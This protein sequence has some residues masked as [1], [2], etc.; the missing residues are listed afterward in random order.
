M[1][2]GR[3]VR[4]VHPRVA[5]SLRTDAGTDAFN[6][7]GGATFRIAKRFVIV[8]QYKYLNFDHRQETDLADFGYDATEQGALIGFGLRF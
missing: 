2:G 4:N 5:L 3:W 8:A 6:V 7:Q 1:A